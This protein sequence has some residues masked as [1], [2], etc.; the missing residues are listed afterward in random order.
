MKKL[1]IKNLGSKIFCFSNVRIKKCNFYSN[2]KKKNELFI[3]SKSDPNLLNSKEDFDDVQFDDRFAPGFSFD[4]NIEDKKWKEEEKNEYKKFMKRVQNGNITPSKLYQTEA[5]ENVKEDRE[6]VDQI[7]DN[8]EPINQSDFALDRITENI[9][10]TE[11]GEDSEM[12]PYEHTNTSSKFEAVVHNYYEEKK[13]DK[14]I[15]TQKKKDVNKNINDK[16][17]EKQIH[18]PLC[19]KK[20]NATSNKLIEESNHSDLFKFL[21]NSKEQNIERM[22]VIINTLKKRK[23]IL[24]DVE[25]EYRDK[26]FSILLSNVERIPYEDLIYTIDILYELNIKNVVRDLS[27]EVIK[28]VKNEKITNEKMT[29]DKIMNDKITN[30]M[31]TNDKITNDKITN[32]KITNDKITND[33]ITNEMITN[34]MITNEMITNEMITNE[35]ITNEMITNEMITNEMIRNEEDDYQREQRKIKLCLHYVTTLN[36][37]S[38]YFA[39]FYDFLITKINYMNNNELVIFANECFKHSLRTKHYLDKIVILCVQKVSEFDL[40]TLQSLYYSFHCFC[41]EYSNFYNSSLTIMMTNVDKF[42]IPFY[43]LLLKIASHFKHEEKYINLIALVSNRLSVHVRNLKEGKEALTKCSIYKS[44]DLIMTGTGDVQH[45][46]G[47]LDKGIEDGSYHNFFLEEQRNDGRRGQTNDTANTFVEDSKNSVKMEMVKG[48]EDEEKVEAGGV[49]EVV[50]TEEAYKGE[51][52]VAE[53]VHPQQYSSKLMKCKTEE[54]IFTGSELKKDEKSINEKSIQII[55]CLRY[56]EYSKRN[57]EEVKIVVNDIFELMKENMECIKLLEIEDVVYCIVCFSSYNKRIV[58]YNNLLDILCERS[59]ELLHAKNISL[60]AIPI[61][62]LSKI[63]W[64]HLNYMTYLFDCIKDNYVLNR[65][66]VFQLLK[67]LSSLVKMNIY[68]EHIYK[69]L[70]E[71]LYND[72]D[73]IKKKFIDIATFLWSCAYVNI[74]YKPL[75]DSS[76]KLIINFLEKQSLSKDA[77]VYKNCFV[78]I[79]WSLIVANYH[80]TQNNFDKILNITFLNRDPNDSQAFKRL[81]QIADACFKEIPK[82]L[83]NL[84]CVDSMYKYCMHEKCKILRNDF[85]IYKKE[86]DAI[87]V[88][89]KILNELIQILKNFNISYDVQFEPYNNCPYI[90]DILLNREMKIGICLFGKEHLMRTL[91]K[92]C[93]DYLNTGFVSLQMRILFAHGWRIIP[94]NAGTWLQL[95]NDEKRTF[96]YECF[97]RHSIQI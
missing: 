80:K 58:L 84:K 11:K 49:K 33:K 40:H 81:H 53:I 2:K 13:Y 61:I 51:N 15:N 85:N 56:L 36:K 44:A 60:W 48:R 69:I 65:L 31:I 22:K 97:K 63:A 38:L 93:W 73:T 23:N 96:L 50:E 7:R 70:I 89:N 18:H 39:D 90:I 25:D 71:K 6:M 4:L 77:I 64:F 14:N 43:R 27:Y 10:I 12:N 32:D 28:M 37:C 5:M 16:Y 34:E 19:Y 91:K 21:V 20:N 29:N 30:E 83:I 8:T 82:S 92:S 66:N 3:N 17:I 68:D 42:N 75:F 94:I 35:M 54:K 1:S 55:K 67:L 26:F 62:S 79:T 45:K 57:R 46:E 74:I 47:K 72:W 88:R 41:K 78:N 95:N 9:Y 87:K 24:L 86:K 59:N 76:Y 52:A